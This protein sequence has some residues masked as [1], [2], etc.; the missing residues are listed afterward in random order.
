MVTMNTAQECQTS[1]GVPDR[2]PRSLHQAQPGDEASSQSP[3]GLARGRGILTV[4]T[5]GR[6]TGG[7]QITSTFF[8]LEGRDVSALMTQQT[9]WEG[10]CGCGW[11]SESER[12]SGMNWEIGIDIH[13]LLCVK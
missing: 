13:T 6:G 2:R 10:E 3:P 11:E 1:P 9:R 7:L 8:R 5:R 4:S 12:E